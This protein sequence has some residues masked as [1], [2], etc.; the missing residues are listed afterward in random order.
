MSEKCPQRQLW[1]LQC[2]LTPGGLRFPP[3]CAPAA[4]C[5][6]EK[7]NGAVR[8]DAL[9]RGKAAH[10]GRMSQ[11]CA[12]GSLEQAREANKAACGVSQGRGGCT[13][14]GQRGVTP[15]CLVRPGEMDPKGYNEKAKVPVNEVRCAQVRF[16]GLTATAVSVN[17]CMHTQ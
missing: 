12:S 2:G 8:C 15:S 16:A 10:C 17:A 13:V 6:G 7:V 4:S 1:W 3:L 11:L 14:I 9:I 5:S